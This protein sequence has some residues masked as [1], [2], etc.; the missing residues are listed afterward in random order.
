MA[1]PAPP[2]ESTAPPLDS[3]SSDGDALPELPLFGCREA[4][5]YR[6]PP[7]TTVGHRAEMWDVN[8]WLATV[9]LRVVQA[10]DDCYV[11]L[12]DDKTGGVPVSSPGQSKSNQRWPLC[13][14][15]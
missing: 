7:A 14:V 11:R 15:A 4:Y 6:V 10:D 13:S 3:G 1:S 5:V 2:K 8:N 12:L 9:S